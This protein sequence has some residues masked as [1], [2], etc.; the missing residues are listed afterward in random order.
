MCWYAMIVY[1]IR[2]LVRVMHALLIIKFVSKR[3]NIRCCK[4][5]IKLM[6]ND[7]FLHDL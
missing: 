5:Y 3:Y 7:D 4:G 1:Q 2:C 6:R